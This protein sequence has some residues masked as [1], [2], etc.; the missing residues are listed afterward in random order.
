MKKTTDRILRRALRNKG[1]II[2][3]LKW[4]AVRTAKRLSRKERQVYWVM[5]ESIGYYVVNIDHVRLLNK[6]EMK[7]PGGKRIHVRDLNS[8]CIWRSPSYLQL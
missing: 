1:F 4:R 2:E 5:K 3:T 8:L 6:N 7:R